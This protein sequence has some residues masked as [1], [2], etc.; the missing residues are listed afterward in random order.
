M[1]C[2]AA[3]VVPRDSRTLRTMH[4]SRRSEPVKMFENETKV[5]ASCLLVVG[6]SSRHTRDEEYVGLEW[7]DALL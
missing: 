5:D 2:L 7:P 6:A 1:Y 4:G 3:N